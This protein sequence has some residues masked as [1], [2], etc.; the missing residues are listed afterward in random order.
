MLIFIILI[1]LLVHCVKGDKQIT[2]IEAFGKITINIYSNK[3]Y[4]IKR[5]FD[6]ESRSLEPEKN[7]SGLKSLPSQNNY[8]EFY[9]T[10][11]K[12]KSKNG[13]SNAVQQISSKIIAK[14]AT[15]VDDKSTYE[16]ISKPK[17][18]LMKN[19]IASLLDPIKN[20]DSPVDTLS[21][22][23]LTSFLDLML[24][25]DSFV[26]LY[27]KAK[28]VTIFAPTNAA[29]RSLSKEEKVM[30][31]FQSKLTDIASYHICPGIYTVDQLH[32]NNI[33]TLNSRY[34]VTSKNHNVLSIQSASII[35][36]NIRSNNSVIH[37]IDKV[38]FYHKATLVDIIDNDPRFQMVSYISRNTTIRSLLNSNFLYTL[39]LPKTSVLLSSG[40]N[41]ST[42]G[43][44]DR[45]H[46][47]RS[48]VYGPGVL[49][50][51]N[52]ATGIVQRLKMSTLKGENISARRI[53]EN[54]LRINND[55][56][57]MEGDILAKN[58][59]IHLAEGILV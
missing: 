11:V 20:D 47:L 59:V 6:G 3:G 14:G 21:K 23:G 44:K 50:L 31:L 53:D 54:T 25:R 55:V 29:F 56:L 2:N 42:M 58:G 9:S 22:L 19:S 34:L 1:Q 5:V 37:V 36:A 39:F 57:I 41:F 40:I 27:L 46:F 15:D 52:F 51:N 17:V 12:K 45:D 7:L 38:L 24:D 49:Y 10:K 48:H 4:A 13:S 8:S 26:N 28:I 43:V 35:S 33:P 18:V 32:S 16:I 30:L